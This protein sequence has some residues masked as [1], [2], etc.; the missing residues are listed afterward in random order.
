MQGLISVVHSLDS[1]ERLMFMVSD[2]EVR[3]LIIVVESN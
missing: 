1:A 2:G 3:G